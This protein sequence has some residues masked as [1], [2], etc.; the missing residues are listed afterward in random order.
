MH[1]FKDL[2]SSDAGL[3][4]A[5]GLAF[6]LGMAVFFV[7]YFLRHIREDAAR[8]DLEKSRQP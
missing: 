5:A 8:A 2:F 7:R 1:A 4:S 6:M 3:M